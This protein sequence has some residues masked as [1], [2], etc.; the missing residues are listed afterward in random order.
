MR[1]FL[2]VFLS[3]TLAA[4][5]ATFTVDL[6][7][8]L[9]GVRSERLWEIP[10]AISLAVREA[11]ADKP[12]LAYD[13]EQGNYLTFR[14]ADGACPVIEATMACPAGRVGI[15]LGAL[16]NPGGRHSVTLDFNGI[17]WSILVDGR[18][19]D[20]DLPWKD[21]PP[22]DG[23]QAKTLSP[24]VKSATFASPSRTDAIVEMVKSRPIDGP[25]QYWTPE[26]HN[27]WLG[28]VSMCQ[29]GGRLHVFYLH[30]R[31]HHRSKDGKGG[32]FFA[33]LSSGDLTHW[34]EHAA[35]VPIVASLESQGTGTPFVWSNRLC[36]AMRLRSL[37][38]V[39][40]ATGDSRGGRYR[41]K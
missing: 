17:Y 6:D 5:A 15:P 38:F 29:Y 31:R 35:A 2:A 28:D 11:G 10:G 18:H 27:A 34:T 32:H 24:R 25:I 8:D 33:H 21:L 39:L 16:A 13:R 41:V 4:D 36:L 14:L 37:N 9:A 19:L 23:T 3:V 40:K 22:I 1:T 26:G 30:D 20:R 12:L 7:V